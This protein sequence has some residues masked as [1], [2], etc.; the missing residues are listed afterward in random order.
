MINPS[1]AFE[2]LYVELLEKAVRSGNRRRFTWLSKKDLID[3]VIEAGSKKGA[4]S[5]KKPSSL[6]APLPSGLLAALEQ[7]KIILD[8]KEE[9]SD[10]LLC[11]ILKGKLIHIKTIEKE[12]ELMRLSRQVIKT[13]AKIAQTA[14]KDKSPGRKSPSK[15]KKGNTGPLP[16]IEKQSQLKK[17]EEIEEEEKYIDDEPKDGPNHYI[18]LSGFYSH[19]IFT[20]LDDFMIPIDCLIK[21]KVA[22]KSLIENFMLEIE[23]RERLE[24][25]LKTN[26]KLNDA[27]KLDRVDSEAF[28]ENRQNYLQKVK[29]ELD[30][31]WLESSKLFEKP[32]DKLIQNIARLKISLKQD[33]ELKSWF[34][35]EARV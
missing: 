30:K 9:I 15:T 19:N 11:Q 14:K 1:D 12:K 21:F 27:E 33:P 13:G 20:Q 7:A 28:S 6:Q 25:N 8:N 34:D 16:E 32:Q 5:P 2:E 10:S 3:S 26:L 23:E 24:T 35:L 4:G 31:F 18:I 29:F 22:N 17:K